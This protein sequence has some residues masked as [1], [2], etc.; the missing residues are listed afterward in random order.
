MLTSHG[1]FTICFSGFSAMLLVLSCG[2]KEVDWSDESGQIQTVNDLTLVQSENGTRDWMLSSDSA[3][4]REA[5]SLLFMTEVNIVFYE[6][7]APE[8]FVRSDTGTSDLINGATILWGNVHA[9]NVNGRTLDTDLLNWSDSLETFETDCLVTF[10]I[11]ESTGTVTTLHGRGV[12]L[13]TGLSAVGDVIVRDSFT[14]VTT[15]E[16]L[17]DD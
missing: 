16:L 15:G 5:D 8:S 1:F 9:E 7:D 11:P 12:I 6:N 3:V 17:L 14:A 13:D 10:V 2:S 4:Y